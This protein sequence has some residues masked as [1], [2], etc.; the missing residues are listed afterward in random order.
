MM[1][2]DA[3]GQE[4]AEQQRHLA[5]VAVGRR[6]VRQA[7]LGLADQLSGV[8]Y[9][10]QGHAAGRRLLGGTPTE[11]EV[12]RGGEAFA[13]QVA[14]DSPGGRQ[15]AWILIGS[16]GALFTT[17]ALAGDATPADER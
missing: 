8:R 16:W 6:Q 2:G 14:H 12:N 10:P 1:H 15:L 9:W 17:E 4:S 3:A 11:Q 7:T 5:Q 13:F